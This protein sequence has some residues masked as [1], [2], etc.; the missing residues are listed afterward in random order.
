MQSSLKLLWLLCIRVATVI[1]G[2]TTGELDQAKSHIRRTPNRKLDATALKHRFGWTSN[3]EEA[4]A[5][6][7]GCSDTAAYFEPPLPPNS[8]DE[9]ERMRLPDFTI[10]GTQ[11]G[12]FFRA[13]VVQAS[14]NCSC[15][16]CCKPPNRVAGGFM[17]CDITFAM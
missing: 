4:L 16:G 2:V 15:F 17:C 3:S 9:S 13:C 1:A 10:I 8:T 7:E 5:L 11:K 12:E 14:H 6:Y